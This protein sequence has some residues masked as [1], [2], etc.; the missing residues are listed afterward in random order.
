MDVFW[1][2]TFKEATGHAVGKPLERNQ[3]N[4]QTV[5]DTVAVCDIM[6]HIEYTGSVPDETPP[7][8]Y[9]FSSKAEYTQVL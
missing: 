8:F 2:K 7:P 1:T 4:P 5:D 9:P 6:P 3:R